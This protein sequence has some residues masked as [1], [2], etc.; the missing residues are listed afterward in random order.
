MRLERGDLGFQIAADLNHG[1]P[2][3]QRDRRSSRQ[4]EI[5]SAVVELLSSV[6]LQPGLQLVGISVR[7]PRPVKCQRGK[8]PRHGMVRMPGHAPVRPKRQHYLW[9]ELAHLKRQLVNDSVQFLAVELSIGIIEDDRLGHSQN[10]AGR[11]KF[12]LAHG[13]QLLIARGSPAVRSRLARRQTDY[14]RFRPAI[15]VGEQRSPKTTGLIIRM[16]GD[17]HESKHAEIVQN[18]QQFAEN[19]ANQC[20]A[21]PPGAKTSSGQLS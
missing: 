12:L 21:S 6:R 7:A 8:H 16:R 5:S 3:S 15:A 1:R 9:P 13:C 19:R 2:W 4:C 17:A 10:F 20:G 14:A 18:T 11:R